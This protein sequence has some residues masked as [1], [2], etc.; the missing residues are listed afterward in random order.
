M[1]LNM[2]L[3]LNK[4]RYLY[5]II[6][7]IHSSFCFILPPKINSLDLIKDNYK[8]RS[9]NTYNYMKKNNDNNYN[10]NDKNKTKI[11][12]II[13]DND[14]LND[15]YEDNETLFIRLVNYC[16]ISFYLY[17]IIILSLSK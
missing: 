1:N 3:S 4:Y 9:I 14:N 11:Y 7:F 15:N 10:H 6:L 8:Y 13:F 2:N 17:L 16:F 12:K 5:L